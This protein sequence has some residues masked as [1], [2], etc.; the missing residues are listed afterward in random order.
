MELVV[1]SVSTAMF[2]P[3]DS[4]VQLARKSVLAAVT[5]L[6]EQIL[7]LVSAI[8]LS[9]LVT[10]VEQTVKLAPVDLSARNASA[11]ISVWILLPAPCTRQLNE[12]RVRF[13]LL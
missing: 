7:E 3:K 5:V 10:T 9:Q 11:E 6:V 13:A 8:T 2:A 12:I 4:G 1:T